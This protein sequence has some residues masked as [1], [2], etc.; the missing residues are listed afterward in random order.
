MSTSY[1]ASQQY[2]QPSVYLTNDPCPGLILTYWCP[3]ASAWLPATFKSVYICL[4]LK[5]PDLDITD[6]KN[7]RLISKLS[8]L[9][10]LLEK[11]VA[12]Q[13]LNYL[14]VN[15]LL[16]DRQSAYR[17][18]G[19]TETAIAGLLSDVLLALD[20]GDIAALPLLDLSAA[21]DTVDH[22][23]LLQPL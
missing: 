11:L 20:N 13:L 3:W 17:A 22:T 19:S 6:F 8:V 1:L 15:K 5:K 2:H 16:P 23:F 18:F 4:L 10:T 14:T 7:Y 21:F 12:W 9:S